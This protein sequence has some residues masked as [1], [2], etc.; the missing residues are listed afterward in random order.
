MNKN[1]IKERINYYRT[2]ANISARNLSFELGMSS[3]YINQIET[4]RLNPSLDF[5]I[6]FCEYFNI[7]LAEFFDENNNYPIENKELT[8]ILNSL[9]KDKVSLLISLAKSMKN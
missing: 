2:H 1:F 3:E 5:I 4:G 6:N 7:T 8:K 9:S